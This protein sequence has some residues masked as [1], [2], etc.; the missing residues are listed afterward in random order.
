MKKFF[1]ERIPQVKEDL[2]QLEMDCSAVVNAVN[3]QD[4]VIN[5]IVAS[6]DEN[7]GQ[8]DADGEAEDWI[9]IYNNT[10]EP[11]ALDGMF[12][13]D[14]LDLPHK[15]SF[16]LGTAI[17]GH[18]YLIVWA[19]KDEQQT[20]LHTNFK[21]SKDGESLKLSH[22]SG[23]T[24]DS[25]SYGEQV[26]NI[27]LARMPNGTGEFVSQAATFNQN[28]ETISNISNSERLH[29]ISVYPNPTKDWLYLNMEGQPSSHPIEIE[30]KDALGRTL[31]K[32]EDIQQFPIRLNLKNYDSGTYFLVFSFKYDRFFKKIILSE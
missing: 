19:D 28:N 30:L 20:G 13:S 12:L 17:D 7:S 26:T 18:G 5:E 15:R 23:T 16:P 6:N 1:N 3:W 22:E 10:D 2:A 27:A 32:R 25:L 11:I 8:V 24:I 31:L 14:N 4:L 9:E 29:D 21:L